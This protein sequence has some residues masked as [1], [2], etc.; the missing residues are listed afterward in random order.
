MTTQ[1]LSQTISR[2][3]LLKGAAGVAGLAAA[4]G[5]LNACVAPG[6]P[7]ASPQAQGGETPF[8]VYTLTP[9]FFAEMGMASATDMYN[10]QLAEEGAAYRIVMEETPDGWETKALA[11]IRENNVRWSASGY[12]QFDEQYRHIRQGLAQ[13]IDDL[14]QG[15]K[16]PWAQDHQNSFIYSNIYETT[17]FEGKTYFIPMKLNIFMAGYRQDYLEAAGYDTL[18][19]TWDE[20]EVMLGKIKETLAEEN[21]VPFAVRK[22]IFRTLGIAFTTFVENPYDENYMLKIDS[23]EFRECVKMFKRWFDQ[24]Y[25]NLQLMQ[26]PMP[27]WQLGKVAVGLDSHSWIRLG[28]SVIEGDKIQGGLPPKTNAS[29]PWRTWIHVDS[30]FVFA[31]APYPQEGLDWLLSILGP[32]G[33]PADRHWSGTLTL[34]GMPVHQNQY[35]RLLGGG[36]ASPELVAAYEA[37]PTSTLVPMEAGKYLPIINAKLIPWMERYWGGEAD[38]E[39]ALQNALDEIE[40]EVEKQIS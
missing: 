21:V 40:Q 16:I 28:R 34:S 17:R 38:L 33:A 20:F 37:V 29:N 23:E 25:T 27:D 14:L 39:I 5:V 8:E 13:P 15:S 1:N 18:P 24:G 36:E 30:S 6:Q 12:S 11:M 9:A 31:G 26:D 32:E 35:D 3:S 19:E 22:D 10:E 2:R 4:S 7:G